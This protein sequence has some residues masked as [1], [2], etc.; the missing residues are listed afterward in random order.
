[1]RLGPLPGQSGKIE[2]V[3]LAFLSNLQVIFPTLQA[4]SR[5]MKE[6][7]KGFDSLNLFE[8]KKA[9]QRFAEC[10]EESKEE[11]KE[12][13]EESAIDCTGRLTKGDYIQ[14][15]NR[16]EASTRRN[17]TCCWVKS[18]SPDMM[19]VVL[20]VGVSWGWGGGGAEAFSGHL[21]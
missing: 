15:D 6:V 21:L 20:K 9:R 14:D 19:K 12:N 17:K 3:M 2:I 4:L 10:K 11:S 1:M 18:K 5:P 8:A 7:I 16:G 13:S